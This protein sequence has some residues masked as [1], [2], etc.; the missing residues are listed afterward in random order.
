MLTLNTDGE[1][2]YQ[3]KCQKKK[4]KQATVAGGCE[5]LWAD[6]L[7]QATIASG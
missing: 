3:K 4:K 6:E 1:F 7:A 2:L 5:L